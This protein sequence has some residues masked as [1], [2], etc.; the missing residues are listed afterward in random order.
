M[1]ITLD[2]TLSWQQ[3][4]QG[5]SLIG[6]NTDTP[7]E[8]LDIV[9]DV[10][11]KN[12]IYLGS[13][14]SGSLFW[15]NS[16]TGSSY[17]N[18]GYVSIGSNVTPSYPLDVFGTVNA[19]TYITSSDRRLKNNITDETYGLDF[20]TTVQPKTFKF[21]NDPTEAVKHGFI[22]QD[23]LAQGYPEFVERDLN[24]ILA[25][26]STSFIAPICKAIQELTEKKLLLQAKIDTLKNAQAGVTVN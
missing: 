6:V 1:T 4:T 18:G 2:L 9:G 16:T 13:N 21:K 20:V 22:A 19:I 8:Q 11:V 23:F 14:S 24:G 12:D 25:I 26:N 10:N 3:A 5:I 15:N 17:I 7:T